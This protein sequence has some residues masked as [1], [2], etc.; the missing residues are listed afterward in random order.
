VPSVYCGGPGGHV[1]LLLFVDDTK[2]AKSIVTETDHQLLQNDLDSLNTWSH[3]WNLPFNETKFRLLHFSSMADGDSCP[4]TINGHCITPSTSHKDL[5]ILFTN[6]LSWE[7]HY[8]LTISKAYRQLSLLRGHLLH[9]MHLPERI[10]I[11]QWSG[12]S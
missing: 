12:H 1:I 4:Y 2:C 6:S 8:N 3:K 9:L 11:S 5:G 10:F 7:E